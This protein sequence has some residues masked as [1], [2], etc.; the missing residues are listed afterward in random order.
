MNAAPTLEMLDPNTLT[1][2][3]NV[4]KD[5]ALTKEF[6]AS[7]KEHGVLVPV[8]A[9]RR[10]DGTVHVLMGQRR[11]LGAIEAGAPR[12]PVLVGDTP[13]EAERLAT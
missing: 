10:E 13:E 11:T 8:V 6:V 2:D 3:I 7:I 5:A 4:R 12:I 9:H 1:V